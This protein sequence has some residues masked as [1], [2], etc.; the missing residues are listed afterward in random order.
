MAKTVKERWLTDAKLEKVKEYASRGLNA[1]QMI[2]QMNI[3]RKQFYELMKVPE[4]KQA[5]EEGNEKSLDLVENA[6][7]KTAMG[8]DYEEVV[9]E[10]V[11]NRDSGKYEMVETRRLKKT[12]PP[13][14]TAQIYILK[15]RRSNQWK[16]KQDITLDGTLN[17]EK[18]I[19]KIQDDNEF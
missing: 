4:F 3:G 11:L 16:D 19:S 2:E 6:L 8:Y 18:V 17:F 13:S 9:S 5:V 10:R 14:Y 1:S 12:Q 7:Y 15:N